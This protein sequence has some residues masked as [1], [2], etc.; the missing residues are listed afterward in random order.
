MIGLQAKTMFSARPVKNA[1]D[2]A[3]LRN[4]GHFGGFVR[5][6]ARNSIR[7][8]AGSSEP[9]QPPSSH[10]GILKGGDGKPGGIF[11]QVEASA[12]GR[13]N[14]VVGPVKT[15]QIFFNNDGRPVRGTVPEVLEKGGEINVFEI[16]IQGR[17]RRADFRSR[18]RIAELD[19]DDKRMRRVT[20]EARPY[21]RPAFAK[22]IPRLPPIW[23]DSVRPVA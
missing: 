20:I 10:Q 14:V 11:Y 4:L 7:K 5:K 18:R 17:W 9:G 6:V 2:K 13:K 8:R 19:A 15:N 21:M 3:D 22:G 1:V 12:L 16:R 23:R